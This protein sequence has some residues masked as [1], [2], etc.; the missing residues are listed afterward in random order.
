[1]CLSL[2]FC[3]LSVCTSYNFRSFVSVLL[4]V[5]S[6]SF[7][8]SLSLSPFVTNNLLSSVCPLFF[9]KLFYMFS[10]F[11]AYSTV[12]LLFY[13]ACAFGLVSFINYRVNSQC[14]F[15]PLSACSKSLFVFFCSFLS[16]Y[17][18]Y[19]LLCTVTNKSPSSFLHRNRN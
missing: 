13:C 6:L 9:S 17:K 19:W 2:F 10:P 8:I 15:Y 12:L 16:L 5:H 1:V 7:S 4:F 3:F 14:K 11:F 18:R